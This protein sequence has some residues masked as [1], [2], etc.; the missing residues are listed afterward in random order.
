MIHINMD[1]LFTGNTKMGYTGP[2][3]EPLKNLSLK[4]SVQ[5]ITRKL[6]DDFCIENNLI[7]SEFVLNIL[8]LYQDYVHTK[9]NIESR[10]I[11]QLYTV[12]FV[13]HLIS[14]YWSAII[15]VKKDLLSNFN[16]IIDSMVISRG[17]VD[18]IDKKRNNI[19][20]Q[21]EQAYNS[22]ESILLPHGKSHTTTGIKYFLF[23]H[24][25]SVNWKY[26]DT[27]LYHSLM[28]L[29][30]LFNMIY[31]LKSTS[32][33]DKHR[34]KKLQLYIYD[35]KQHSK[36]NKKVFPQ[37]FLLYAFMLQHSSRKP[38]NKTIDVEKSMEAEGAKFKNNANSKSK[39]VKEE[40][41]QKKYN[42][43]ENDIHGINHTSTK[44][45]NTRTMGIYSILDI[46]F[47]LMYHHPFPF[48]ASQLE[49]KTKK[50]LDNHPV[51]LANQQ[52]AQLLS[53]KMNKK[54]SDDFFSSFDKEQ[55]EVMGEIGNYLQGL[56]GMGS[57][58]LNEL[59][60]KQCYYDRYGKKKCKMFS[61][62]EKTTLGA[63]KMSGSKNLYRKA[64]RNFSAR[65]R[66]YSRYYRTQKRRQYM[67]NF[68]NGMRRRTRNV[69][70]RDR[71]TF[72]GY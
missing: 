46:L 51:N 66:D 31:T 8:D 70:T 11:I 6:I 4:D 14:A 25:V 9:G 55:F 29:L 45:D 54:D 71:N 59:K 27:I 7:A 20:T 37:L 49:S 3:F 57:K 5:L 21:L 13:L 24:P 64:S 58:G 34:Q 67:N 65:N 56:Y 15:A 1:T 53:G 47:Q 30:V 22:L 33:F 69:S 63:L 17:N 61:F 68:G 2:K 28:L 32:K 44:N 19:T 39:E 40:N 16:Q 26:Y 72:N 35:K 60:Q 43:I 18:G 23:K 52:K 48:D 38:Y 50:A 36:I 41:R 12:Y 42:Q 62:A 10:G